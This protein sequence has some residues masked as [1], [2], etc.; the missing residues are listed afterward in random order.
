VSEEENPPLSVP[1]CPLPSGE[2]VWVRG[3]QYGKENSDNDFDLFE[4]GDS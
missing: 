3:L 2:R 1:I 4:F